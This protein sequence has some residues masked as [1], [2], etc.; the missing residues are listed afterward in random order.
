M[1]SPLS[2][3]K[4]QG[5]CPVGRIIGSAT[6]VVL[7][8]ADFFLQFGIERWHRPPMGHCAMAVL[9]S[10]KNGEDNDTFICIYH[11]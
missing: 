11:A 4:R 1:H 5:G 7:I 9:Y 3:D 10:E 6:V 2:S 8:A